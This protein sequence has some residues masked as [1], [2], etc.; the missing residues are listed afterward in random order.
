MGVALI[1][2]LVVCLLWPWLMKLLRVYMARRAEDMLRR[3]A[4]APPRQKK[5]RNPF[6]GKREDGSAKKRHRRQQPPTPSPAQMMR[7]V[8]EDVEYTEIR[9]FTQ[10]TERV[11]DTTRTRTVY[12]ESQVEDAKYTE[13][14]EFK[15]QKH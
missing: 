15:H 2:L 3:M 12:H 14:K 4:G 1:I 9:E 5:S 7:D 11:G 6:K 8:A 10:T 13:V